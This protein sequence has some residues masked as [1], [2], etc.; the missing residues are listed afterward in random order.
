MY[1]VLANTV[2]M[3]HKTNSTVFISPPNILVFHQH[4]VF[5]S[6]MD[7]EGLKGKRIRALKPFPAVLCHYLQLTWLANTGNSRE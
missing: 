3:L 4:S 2:E 5:R 6:L 1:F 7:K